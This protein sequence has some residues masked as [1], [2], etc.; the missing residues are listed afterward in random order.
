MNENFMEFSEELFSGMYD[1]YSTLTGGMKQDLGQLQWIDTDHML[2][3]Y[4][5]ILSECFFQVGAAKG[6]LSEED[7]YMIKKFP[8][9]VM[10]IAADTHRYAFLLRHISLE[11]YEKN[12]EEVFPRTEWDFFKQTYA[13][14][15]WERPKGGTGDNEYICEIVDRTK[16]LFSI[17]TE[18][19]RGLVACSAFLDSIFADNVSDSREEE[20]QESVV[21]GAEAAAI[22]KQEKKTISAEDKRKAL[23]EEKLQ[24]LNELIGLDPVKEEI[25]GLVYSYQVNKMRREMGIDVK[26][27]LSY[28][29][30]F[31][32]NPGTGKTTVARIVADIYYCLDIIPE[33]KYTETDAE[34]LVG[35]YVGETPTKTKRIAQEAMGGVLFIDEAYQ[36]VDGSLAESYGQEAI[37]TLVKIM[38]DHRNELILIVAGY[39]EDMKKFLRANAGLESRFKR[40]IEFPDYS[41]EEMMQILE[42]FLEGWI[43]SEE[44]RAY[45]LE[46]LSEETKKRGFANGRTVRKIAGKLKQ[47][48]DERIG[49]MMSAGS[50]EIRKELLQTITMEDAARAFEEEEDSAR[51]GF[52]G[53][54]M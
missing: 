38:E 4:D 39:P 1:V 52:C 3:A 24:E 13:E 29:L 44:T 11:N 53:G 18:D 26:D 37:D 27:D 48:V 9:H 42:H 5:R 6:A 16:E 35:R 12:R 31:S 14:L 32:G 36:L 2:V 23:L 34:G 15:N 54:V 19:E 50:L 41:P 30:I 20:N 17:Y 47:S 40:T 25:S 22:L 28:H 43:L 33:P 8:D 7:Q 51:I 21:T 45:I 10:D 49:R 46:N